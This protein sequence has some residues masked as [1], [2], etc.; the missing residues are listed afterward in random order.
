M[1]MTKSS[2][3]AKSFFAIAQDKFHFAITG[4]TAAQIILERADAQMSN[5][6]LTTMSS[7]RADDTGGDSRE[8]LLNG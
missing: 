2:Q 8:K 6:G 7:A 3:A 5:M 4:Q 1:T